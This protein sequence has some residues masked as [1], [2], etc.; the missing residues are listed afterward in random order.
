MIN[1]EI[2]ESEGSFLYEEAC[3]SVI[4]YAAKVKRAARVVVQGLDM[5]GNPVEIKATERMAVVFQH[6]IDHLDGILFIDRISKLKRD[7]YR[8]RL[9]KM[10]RNERFNEE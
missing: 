10:M 2:V 1:P 7:L 9:K 4:D 3:L 5:D 6:E 8:R